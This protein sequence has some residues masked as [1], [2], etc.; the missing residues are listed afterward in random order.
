M[1]TND[2]DM[3]DRITY[4]LDKHKILLYLIPIIVGFF[5]SLVIKILNDI[6]IK[7]YFK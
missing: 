7:I 4:F 1:N 5:G 2:K 3:M 6:F